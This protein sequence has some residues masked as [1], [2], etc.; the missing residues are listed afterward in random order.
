MIV[1]TAI[2]LVVMG[3]T[4]CTSQSAHATQVYL[5]EIK[6]V[7]GKFKRSTEVKGCA[8]PSPLKNGRF[9]PSPKRC[10]VGDSSDYCR[11]VP[12]SWV[13]ENSLLYYSCDPGY[14]LLTAEGE[15][16]LEKSATACQSGQWQPTPTCVETHY[17]SLNLPHFQ[18]SSSYCGKTAQHPR[19]KRK[20]DGTV[21][22]K[23]AWPWMVILGMRKN[24][25]Q[26]GEFHWFCAGTL[27]TT[28]HILTAAHCVADYRR[29]N[30]IFARF[31][32]IDLDDKY[33]DKGAIDIVIQKNNTIAIHP[34]FK[35]DQKFSHNLA[36]IK[37][38]SDLPVS[39]YTRPICLPTPDF[40]GKTFEGETAYFASWGQT[41]NDRELSRKRHHQ[42]IL[43]EL[44]AT[45]VNH[46]EC[47]DNYRNYQS[48]DFIIVGWDLICVSIPVNKSCQGDAGSPLMLK[49][50]DTY[51]LIG[52]VAT[53][54]CYNEVF[55]RLF[56]RLSIYMDWIISNL[57]I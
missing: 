9:I 3:Y 32:D 20:V 40:T 55:P 30:L 39:D 6:D 35:K 10:P 18:S 44:Q 28:R 50:K 47:K 48:D 17:K 34:G 19:M 57:K 52:V 46:A 56:T 13:P 29:R 14:N 38:N 2:V 45:V 22:K 54:G 37:M 49:I 26:H 23:G 7:S 5:T 27:V 53:H 12:G 36:I 4:L 43:H 15:I 51:V 33:D 24:N 1:W 41:D 11:M 8:L 42:L 25:T 16:T 31:S 21:S